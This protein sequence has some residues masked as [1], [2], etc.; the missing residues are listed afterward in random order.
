NATSIEIKKSSRNRTIRQTAE[1]PDDWDKTENNHLANK[2][3]N[4]IRR[5]ARG[6]THHVLSRMFPLQWT[7]TYFHRCSHCNGLARTFM[8]FH[9]LSHC[10]ELSRTFIDVLI[11]MDFHVLSCAF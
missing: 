7:F 8:C 5:Y 1:E 3:N 11:A 10:N 4:L 9:G 2:K 6:K